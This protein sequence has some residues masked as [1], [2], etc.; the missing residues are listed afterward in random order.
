MVGSPMLL[1]SLYKEH[2]IASFVIKDQYSCYCSYKKQLLIL[3]FKSNNSEEDPIGFFLSGYAFY[4]KGAWH[5]PCQLKRLVKY[6]VQDL[7]THWH[8]VIAYLIRE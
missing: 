6:L 3:G 8:L 7:S 5:I 1:T 4:D 2:A